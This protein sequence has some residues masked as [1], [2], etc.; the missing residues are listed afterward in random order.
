M[1]IPISTPT[2]T[3]LTIRSVQGTGSHEMQVVFSAPHPRTPIAATIANSQIQVLPSAA[4][5]LNVPA[6][7]THAE[8]AVDVADIRWWDDG[9][10]PTTGPSGNGKPLKAGNYMWVES[11]S[12]FQMIAQSTT[13][14]V[15]ISFYKYA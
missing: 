13:A 3:D 12:T 5:S 8:I 4:V 11:P 14:V 9:K 15:T 10:V 1:A 2:V 6:G 7:A